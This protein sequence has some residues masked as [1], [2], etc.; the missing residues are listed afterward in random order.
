[1]KRAG[2][3]TSNDSGGGESGKVGKWESGRVGG[4]EKG[5]RGKGE[6]GETTGSKSQDR[7]IT[8]RKMNCGL[9][10]EAGLRI[11]LR[12]G[13]GTVPTRT[14]MVLALAAGTATLR[15]GCGFEGGVGAGAV[16]DVDDVAEEL[17]V[18]QAVGCFGGELGLGAE[19]GR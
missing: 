3:K 11:R 12:L 6:S 4:W 7:K 16:D 13:V 2:A 10:E 1:M 8:D 15:S 14:G 18:G 5:K 19:V 17:F 9:H